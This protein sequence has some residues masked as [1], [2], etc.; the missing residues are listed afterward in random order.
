MF[1]NPGH[2]IGLDPGRFHDGFGNFLV[3]V[4]QIACV[5]DNQAAF[6]FTVIIQKVRFFVQPTELFTGL[7]SPAGFKISH[8]IA[9]VGDPEGYAFGG[10][11]TFSRKVD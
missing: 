3:F 6:V 1:E 8:N 5:D 11:G 2:V 7:R 4:Q 9:A 10:M